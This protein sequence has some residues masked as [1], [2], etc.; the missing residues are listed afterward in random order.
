VPVV[1][2][3]AALE[4]RHEDVLRRDDLTLAYS[5]LLTQAGREDEAIALLTRHRFHPWEGGE[6]VALAA[7]ASAHQAAACRAL[8]EGRPEEAVSAARAALNPP[9]NLGEAPHPLANRAALLLDLGDALEAAGDGAAARAAWASAEASAGDFSSTAPV[10]YPEATYPSIVAA[11]RLGRAE[12]AARLRESLRG[13]I[14]TLRG[15]PAG[16]DY[17]AAS[18]PTIL[19]FDE[20]VQLRQDLL[21]DLLTA[22]LAL[23]D[24][25]LTA[26]STALRRVLTADPAHLEANRLLSQI[27][28]AAG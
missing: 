6:G 13:Y 24:G 12:A 23:L 9:G 19:T 17:F 5:R 7:W 1:D 2:R 18:L 14:A 10:P 27:R 15:T 28:A 16:I 26:A 11:E 21:A 25:D 20:D 8:A 22:Q 4:A 3:L